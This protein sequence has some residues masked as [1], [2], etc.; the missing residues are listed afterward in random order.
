MNKKMLIAGLAVALAV[1]VSLAAYA[2]LYKSVIT[3]SVSVTGMS[4]Q[5]KMFVHQPRYWTTTSNALG[6][7]ASSLAAGKTYTLFLGV[8]N[9]LAEETGPTY[10]MYVWDAGSNHFYLSYLTNYT[11]ANIEQDSPDIWFNAVNW[12]EYDYDG[13]GYLELIGYCPTDI[14]QGGYKIPANYWFVTEMW[15]TL[16]NIPTLG[17][18]I[19]LKVCEFNSASDL[20]YSSGG[21]VLAGVSG[22]PDTVDRTYSPS[23]WT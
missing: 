16:G 23:G 17:N 8:W 18:G 22:L 13:D 15:F 14:V 9:Q 5:L 20:P 3:T 21:T 12:Y 4:D 2:V 11:E 19:T 7:T 10:M 1:S 6:E